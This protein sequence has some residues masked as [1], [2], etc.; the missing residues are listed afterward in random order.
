[1]VE[2]AF[3][4]IKVKYAIFLKKASDCLQHEIPYSEHPGSTSELQTTV[5]KVIEVARVLFYLDQVRLES[6]TKIIWS[7]P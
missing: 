4:S 2:M 1:M 3:F 6:V 7:N 5:G